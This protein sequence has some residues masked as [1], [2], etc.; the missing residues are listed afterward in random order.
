MIPTPTPQPG[1]PLGATFAPADAPARPSAT[2]SGP[3]IT[4]AVVATTSTATPCPTMQTQP[5][6]AASPWTG[7]VLAA[8]LTAVVTLL[9]TV[10]A[11]RRK[12]RE[13]ERAR[14]RTVFAEAYQAYTEYKE[15][16]Y[17][18]HRRRHDEPAAE[19]VRVSEILR[20]IQARLRY[21]ETWTAAESATVGTAYSNLI[22]EVRR[23]A[24]GAMRDAWEKQPITDDTSMNIPPAVV[25]LTGLE[26]FERAYV[27]AFHAHLEDIAPWW[28]RRRRGRRAGRSTTTAG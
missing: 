13:E 28:P 5:A 10:W 26:P 23:I 11:A 2:Q 9:L 19:R 27:T 12:S 25:D 3:S 24:G 7:P 21:Y 20:D 15:M 8:L 17:A 18:I 6:G 22:S 14:Q 16:P 1:M 4:P